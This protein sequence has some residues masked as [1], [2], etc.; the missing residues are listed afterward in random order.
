MRGLILFLAVAYLI[1]GMAA[2]R[3]AKPWKA[4]K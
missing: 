3:F 1:P 2:I 4:D